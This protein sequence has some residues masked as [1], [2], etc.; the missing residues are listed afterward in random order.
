M[1]IDLRKLSVLALATAFFASPVYAED[2]Q[3]VEGSS[4]GY[5]VTTGVHHSRRSHSDAYKAWVKVTN[6]SGEA[7]KSFELFL[8]VGDT[9]IRD[10]HQSGHKGKHGSKNNGKGH[11]GKHG[12]KHNGKGHKGKSKH[13]NKVNFT[14]VD[15]GYFVNSPSRLNKKGIQ[16]G[17]SYRFNFIGEGDY[18]GITPYV[19]SI[20][21]NVCDA[22]A[23]EV[24]VSSSQ[25]L[26]TSEGVLT[27][28]ADAS[29]NVAV[30]KVVFEQDGVVIGEDSEAPFSL[31]VD[32]SDDLNGR[33]TY[34]ATAYDP[35]G[36]QASSDSI[37]VFVTIDDRFLGTAP[38]SLADF[39]EIAYFNQITPEDAGK[40]GTV[41]AVRNEMNWDNLD[42]AYSAAQ[43]MGMPFKLHTLVWGQQAP[44]WMND[45]S[46]E[47]QLAELEEWMYLLAERYPDSEMVDVV[48]EALHAPAGY[49]EALGGAG[50][51]GWDWVIK[52]FELARTYFPD[53]QL[54]LNDYSI[55]ILESF[56]LDYLQIIELLQD[57]DLIDGIGLQAHF[58][59]RAE[60]SVVKS[61]LQLLADTGLPIYISELDVNF[62]DDARQAIRLSELFT[63]FWE[64]PAVVGVTHWG[65]LQGDIWR[66]DAYLIRSDKTLR[67][68]M[69]WL[70]CYY[71]GGEDCYV[72]E[73]VPA[74]W[75][76]GEYGLT[77]QGEE[78]DDAFGLVALGNV[79]S[80]TDDGDWLSYSGVNFD[81]GWDTFWLT[82]LKGSDTESSIS[83]HLDSLDAA[84]IL[85]LDLAS[86]GGWGT[87]ETLSV[88]LGSISGEHDVYVRFNGTWGVANLDSIRF[89][90]P[91]PETGYGPNLMINPGFEDS[92]TDGWFTWDGAI[93]ATTER[94]Y[95]GV[96]ALQLSGRSG[97]GPA[98]YGLLLNEVNPGSTY[99]VSMQVSISGAEQADVNVTQKIGCAGEDDY[100]WLINPVTITDGLWGEL[101]GDL[102]I[103]DCELTDV[104]IYLEGPAG[105]ID[106][107]IDN[108]S[109]REVLA[110]DNL[111]GNGDFEGGDTSGWF[112]WDGT[113]SVTTENTYSGDYS[114]ELSNRSGNG[115]A[116][117]DLTSL[118]TAG[119]SYSVSLATS[120]AG[121]EEASVNITQKIVCDDQ[122]SY[123]W[124]A[125]TSS[126]LEGDWVVLTGQ[127]DVPDCNLTQLLIYVEGP[128]GGVDLY[129]DDL[130]VTSF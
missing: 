78:Y 122:A 21:G 38:G 40:W 54:L 124:L 23:P 75:F 129:V 56:T 72:P 43:D 5:S 16:E 61:N 102:V 67:P 95:S 35:T 42:Y 7:A 94:A 41:E 51:T 11:N 91:E 114:L 63:I 13:H 71:G 27:L 2:T 8:D 44:G 59:E 24:S 52:S 4:C 106:L 118:V 110:N 120:I 127:L 74:G 50:E 73:Y 103:P 30:L 97:N 93:S 98:A 81:A 125:N 128:A 46:A 123:S 9:E 37:R 60:L 15:G 121:A 64:N 112:T 80:Y 107:F 130:I 68:A 19:I 82:Y 3:E 10:T 62:S 105:G 111:V 48:N 76:G 31:D 34:S 86:T 65:H 101:S 79:A 49:R 28:T 126:L 96:Y 69:E 29:D 36:N 18:T 26:L 58:L 104:L 33:H 6:E 92:S 119:E 1:K 17:R 45:L 14:K 90:T 47:E 117:Y 100:Q 77:L 25:S 89:G 32:I 115:P 108:V 84:P 20:N 55:L 57:R 39:D 53:A 12:S 70:S 116:A 113:L 66:E 85:S 83:I 99:K 88:A 87:S 22:V 109:V